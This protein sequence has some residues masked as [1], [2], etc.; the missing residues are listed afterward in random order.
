MPVGIEAINAYVGRASLGVEQLF[1]ARGLDDRRL[2]NLMMERK[3]VNLPCEDPV[4]NAVN[5]ARPLVQ[6]LTDDERDRIE[7][8]IVGTES[9]LDFGKPISTYIQ[10][11]LGLTRRCRS[12]EVK[13]ACYGATAALQAAAAMVAL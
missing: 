7:L 11:Y 3:S 4:T 5:A 6:A 9:G 10:H 1:E 2:G 13:H 8:I 12:F